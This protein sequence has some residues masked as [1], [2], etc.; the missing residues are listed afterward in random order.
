MMYGSGAAGNGLRRSPAAAAKSYTITADLTRPS[1]CLCLS[2]PPDNSEDSFGRRTQS[3]RMKAPLKRRGGFHRNAVRQ[4]KGGPAR[5][6]SNESADLHSAAGFPFKQTLNGSV[7]DNFPCPQPV[8][9][10]DE[11]L[12]LARYEQLSHAETRA[13]NSCSKLIFL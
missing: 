9:A 5:R 3:P 12:T 8:R 4:E 1:L 6:H 2:R 7:R 13:I 11:L 10:G